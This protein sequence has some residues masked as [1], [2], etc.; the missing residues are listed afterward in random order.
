[1]PSWRPGRGCGAAIYAYYF[2]HL[3]TPLPQ[4]HAQLERLARLQG[5][6]ADACERSH[7]EES[8]AG[9]VRELDEAVPFVG[10]EPFD[11]SPNHQ[12]GW[13]V[14]F[15]FGQSRR[16]VGIAPRLS[17]IIFLDDLRLSLMAISASLSDEVPNR[18]EHA[19]PPDLRLLLLKVGRSI[20]TGADGSH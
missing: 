18:F 7:V 20:T 11:L 1:M 14:E 13:C 2:R 3:R 8:V 12:A 17:R 4:S 16:D 9:P 10:V 5:A 15:W 6:D 19:R